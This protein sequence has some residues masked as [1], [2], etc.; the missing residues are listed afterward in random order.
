MFGPVSTITVGASSPS[1]ISFGITS[2]PALWK[3]DEHAKC[4]EGEGEGG[5]IAKGGDHTQAP[6]TDECCAVGQ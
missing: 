3:K 2:F 4:L 5:K 1:L 6:R